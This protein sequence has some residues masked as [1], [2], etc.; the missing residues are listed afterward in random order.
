MLY[1]LGNIAL[2]ESSSGDA[3]EVRV[4]QRS[5]NAI[6]VRLEDDHVLREPLDHVRA[7]G[8]TVE[9]ELGIVERIAAR[10]QQAV[11]AAG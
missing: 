11:A 1:A 2:T 5:W 4:A 3:S 6:S 9:E 7:A 10:K 8:F